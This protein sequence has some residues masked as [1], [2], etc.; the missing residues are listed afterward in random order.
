MELVYL[1]NKLYLTFRNN[2]CTQSKIEHIGLQDEPYFKYFD[3]P[4]FLTMN[5][6]IIQ[7]KK[8]A[9]I[10][11]KSDLLEIHQQIMAK[12]KEVKDEIYHLLV[13]EFKYFG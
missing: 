5:S 1:V 8:Y 7:I 4:D 11:C 6:G 12:S 10:N 3:Y 9:E 13:D 2:Y